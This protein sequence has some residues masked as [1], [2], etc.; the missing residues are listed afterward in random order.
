VRL[1]RAHR[2]LAD[3]RFE[4]VRIAEIAWNCGFSEPSHFSRRFRERFGVP[5]TSFRCNAV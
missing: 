4:D 5:P 3:K 2:L 1:E